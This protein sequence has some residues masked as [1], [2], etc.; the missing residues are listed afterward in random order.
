MYWPQYS[1]AG[2]GWAG[3]YD[4]FRAKTKFPTATLFGE[5]NQV[6]PNDMDQGSIGDCYFIASCSGAAELDERVKRL[7][8]TQTYNQ[9][10]I[11]VMKGMVLGQEQTIVVD[12]VLPFKKGTVSPKLL[13]DGLSDQNSLWGPFIEKAWAKVHGNYNAIVG[14]TGSEVF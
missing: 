14:G 6:L 4:L 11:V 12:D 10:G 8:I 7:F 9:E 3:K 1:K 13:F 2:E 5:K